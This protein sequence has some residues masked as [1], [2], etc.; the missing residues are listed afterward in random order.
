MKKKI[1]I[2]FLICSGFLNSTNKIDSKGNDLIIKLKQKSK[3][4]TTHKVSLVS[5]EF[6]AFFGVWNRASNWSLGTIPSSTDNVIVGSGRVVQINEPTAQIASLENAGTILV[7]ANTFIN[8]SGDLTNTG[9]IILNS[10]ASQSASILVSGTSTGSIVYNK[11]VINNWQMISSPV[12]G[13]TIENIISTAPLVSG[14]NGNL[15]FGSY[16]NSYVLPATSSWEYVKENSTGSIN[17]G[18]GY[19]VKRSG[20]GFITFGGS[21]RNINTSIPITNGTQNRWNLIGNPYPSYIAGNTNAG[22]SN[23]LDTNINEIEESFVGLYFW[24]ATIQGFEVINNA[25]DAKFIP[26]G[27]GFFIA[28]KVGGGTISITK[29][30]LSHQITNSSKSANNSFK[31]DI[32]ATSGSSTKLSKLRYFENT[33]TG[34]D[35]GYD[36]GLFDAGNESFGIY[37]KLVSLENDVNFSLQC[38]P[39]SN[40]DGTIIPLGIKARLNKE[41]TFNLNIENL[42]DDLKVFLED[43][44]RNTFTRL[45]F[46]G[47]EYSTTI[48]EN[49]K[50]EFGR[51]YLHTTSL[52][53]TLSTVGASLD[54]NFRIFINNN[55]LNI[56]VGEYNSELNVYNILG[57]KLLSKKISKELKQISL[58]ESMVA[59][60]YVIK[61]KVGEVELTKRFL[62]K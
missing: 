18:V 50:H 10:S 25:S 57:Q 1:M 35:L 8:I 53:K 33:T 19:T 21:I 13:E 12:T 22:V 2:I 14:T 56:D 15:G 43:K 58:P 26:P 32:I 3:K 9:N 47:S 30:M 36:A 38:L 37:S 48:L 28:S 46:K 55:T 45:D 16:N 7:S 42:P 54:S 6:T 60:I 44:K 29:N 4:T 40:I 24:N 11:H 5:N 27:T 59:G 51:F 23:I 34:L 62:I 49:D 41:I 20:D 61:L 17:S 52:A 39:E 31:I